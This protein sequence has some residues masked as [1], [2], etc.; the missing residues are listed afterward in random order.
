MTRRVFAT[1]WLLSALAFLFSATPSS[2]QNAGPYDLQN[3]TVY[4]TAH[5]LTAPTTEG[6][7]A[8]ISEIPG[9][10]EIVGDD[11]WRNTPARTL[12]D[13][14]DFTPGVFAQPKWGE[15][16]RLSIR[17][18]GLSRNFHLRGVQLF[19][20]GV[21]INFSDGGADFQEIDPTAF[22]YTEVYKGGNGLRYGANA[23]GGAINFVSPTGY[24][25]SLF[26]GR[27]DIGSFGFYRAQA[28]TGGNNGVVDGF[29]TGSWLRQEGFRRHSAGHSAHGTGNVGWRIA[30]NV[31]T[32]FYL[33]GVDLK[34]EIP[35]SVT[36]AAALS[37]PRTPLPGNV[38][39]NYQ[40]NM[41]TW[42]LSNK[43]AVQLEN[44][45]IEFGG[46]I[47]EKHLIHPIYQY[48]DYRYHDF[49]GFG[50]VTGEGSVGGHNDRFALGVTQTAGWADNNQSVNLPG[51]VK[52]ALLSKSTDRAT[53]TIV[54]GE[55]GFDLM[56]KVTLVAGLQYVHAV[57]RR[58]DQLPAPPDTS[59]RANYN[60][61]NPKLGLLWQVKPEWQIFGNVSW[62]GEAPTFSEL[63][64]TNAALAS[65]NA[66]RATTYEIGTRGKRDGVTWD[67]S[68]YRSNIR[69]EFQFFDLGGG[70]YQVVNANNTVHQGIELGGGFAIWRDAGDGAEIR[71][72]AAYTFSDF[73]FD[74][75]PVWKDNQLPGAPA[76]YLRAELLYKHPAGFYAG[77]NIEWVPEAYP[78]DNA[79][80]LSTQSYALL[81]VRAGYDFNEHLSVFVDA[82]NLADEKYIASVST[83]AVANAGSALF[84]PGSG[85]AVYS[86]LR[87]RW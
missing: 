1:E 77:P 28:S 5:S 82:R 76:H 12:K 54:Y 64:F 35:G 83:A 50:R 59:G 16:T 13:V 67:V 27:A 17:G 73:R 6:A 55:N 41:T 11:A 8:Q 36:R 44:V 34:Q 18:S 2:A 37:D 38:L 24:D 3:I 32:R 61:L 9:G 10:A 7:E 23:L 22:R 79:H 84:E 86:G 47:V 14:L 40:R 70:N 49:G 52:G 53:N 15:D 39:Q 30:D 74:N 72:N 87:F 19:Q 57:R 81:G 62:S 60:F 51:A 45:L 29:L 25:T 66:Q 20:D 75:D 68:L 33:A 4:G 21:P 85:R 43:T 69:H 56:P 26:D 65:L 46:Y 63:N 31:E 58:A 48:L 78:V 71:L 80:N 42:R